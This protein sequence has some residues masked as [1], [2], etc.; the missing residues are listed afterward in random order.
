MFKKIQLIGCFRGIT[1]QWISLGM[2]VET[3]IKSKLEKENDI[4][5]VHD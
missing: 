2:N 1:D 3:V 5:I 4:K